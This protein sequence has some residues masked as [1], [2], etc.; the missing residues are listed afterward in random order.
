MRHASM[1]ARVAQILYAQLRPGQ[2]RW[3]YP[4]ASLRCP[5]I[6]MMPMPSPSL[7]C[8]S[9]LASSTSTQSRTTDRGMIGMTGDR[10]P[11]ECIIERLDASIMDE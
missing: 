2:V 9:L 6:A 8:N 4:N 3:P 1:L 11:V 5:A 7:N 10:D